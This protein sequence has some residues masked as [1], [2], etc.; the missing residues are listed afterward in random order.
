MKHLLCTLALCV[1]ATACR[2]KTETAVRQ[3]VPDR[4]VKV[5]KV[6]SEEH[7]VDVTGPSTVYVLQS[8][9]V[10]ALYEWSH[11]RGGTIAVPLKAVDDGSGNPL[12]I[13]VRGE[14]VPTDI[15]DRFNGTMCANCL[16]PRSDYQ[17]CP[18]N[19]D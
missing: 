17:C 9:R 16:D 19:A 10:R 7:V 3:G 2:G 11:Q 18:R 12:Y 1:V 14:P 4:V 13:G 6:E 5:E 15:G 8:G